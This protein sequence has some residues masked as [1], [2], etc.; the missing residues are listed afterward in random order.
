[1]SDF[2]YSRKAINQEVL[3]YRIQEIY[4]KDK[5]PVKEFHGSWGS[6]A[7]S[8][9]LYNGFKPYENHEHICIVLGGP[10]LCFQENSFLS[11]NNDGV[12]GTEAI[13][14]RWLSNDIKWDED[15]SGPFVILII[16]KI[17][18]KVICVTD[19][20]SF[21]P[22]FTYREDSNI[23]L[24]THVDI[25]ARVS[26]QVDKFDKTSL[27]DF[28]L[29]GVVT[30]PYT[31]YSS[32]KQI[33][34]ASVC[35]IA[36]SL[37][38]K[39]T[40][41]W[42]PIEEFKYDSIDKAASDLRQCLKNY[43][44]AITKGM[45]HV[46]LFLSGGEDSRVVA[47]LLTQLGKRDAYIFLDAMN[48]EG[49]IAKKAALAYGANL[50]TAIR[51]TNHYLEIMPYCADLVGSGS[52]FVHVH[53]FGFH[54]SCR[55]DEYPAV[56]GGLFSDAFLKGSHITKIRGMSLMPF[57][58][59]L[60]RH[61]Y[62]VEKPIDKA[63]KSCIFTEEVL[64]ELNERRQ[65]H[66]NYV[67]NYRHNSAEE[68]FELW[69]S[70][71]NL[72]MPNIHGNRR[73][74]R[75]YEPFMSKDVIKIS[76]VVPQSWKLNRR[77]FNRLAKPLL[78]PSKWLLHGD[79][80][81]PYFPWYINSFVQ[82]VFWFSR[83]VTYRTGIVKG[84]QGPWNDWDTVMSS[85]EWQEAVEKYLVGITSIESALKEKDIKK[86]FRSSQLYQYQKISLMQILYQLNKNV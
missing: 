73:L 51:S 80:R 45:E 28:L 6:L 72:N 75:S 65:A 64:S 37:M 61:S 39:T 31:V 50:N 56:F 3:T 63:H 27:I 2:V 22:V 12:E 21:I 13:Y 71:M 83:Q 46:A 10:L 25:L 14:K 17:T 76:A 8:Y 84:N 48:R 57:L 68:W 85:S 38:I 29:N 9:N 74:F 44:N 24:S 4:Y 34:P 5:P 53:T 82:F 62:T 70:S 86:I 11:S 18:S 1:M 36:G 15:L 52:Q 81:L 35:T 47:A 49:H 33:A 54:K 69:P 41:Y 16:N 77:L 55:L 23:I 67:K 58:P 30:Y 59:Q 42:S 79:G 40:D 7:V 60:K 20:M 78:V 43:V 66:L 26:G 32:L 19:L